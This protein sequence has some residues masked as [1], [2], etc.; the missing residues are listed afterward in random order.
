MI[1]TRAGLNIRSIRTFVRSN[2][3]RMYNSA[4]KDMVKPIATPIV[5]VIIIIIRPRVR[6][7]FKNGGH[8]K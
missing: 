3:P 6:F 8:W 7:E 4:S 5:I 1:L 2:Q